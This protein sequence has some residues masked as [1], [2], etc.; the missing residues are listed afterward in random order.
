VGTQAQD[1]RRPRWV[2]KCDVVEQGRVSQR[3]EHDRASYQGQ[4]NY[5]ALTCPARSALGVDAWAPSAPGPPEV[6][7]AVQTLHVANIGEY[8][9]TIRH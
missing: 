1:L 6:P 4:N 9:R 5:R 3:A 8:L 7:L 2:G